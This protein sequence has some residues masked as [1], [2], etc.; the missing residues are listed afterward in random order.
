MKIKK[1]NEKYEIDFDGDIAE[2]H[3]KI[4]LSEYLDKML[5]GLTLE[6]VFRDIVDGDELEED[7][8]YMIKQALIDLTYNI[9][10]DANNIRSKLEYN[11]DKY[12][13]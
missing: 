1:F 10:N 8:E 7:Q 2:E 4:I 11:S 13:L 5:D 12:N 9:N 3:A 6:E